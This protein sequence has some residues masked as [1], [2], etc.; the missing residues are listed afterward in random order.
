[1]AWTTVATVAV[2]DLWT[3]ARNNAWI[4]N[5]FAAD[6]PSGFTGK[7]EIMV[8]SGVNT[9]GRLNSLSFYYA[10]LMVSPADFFGVTWTTSVRGAT[11]SYSLT[12]SAPN[13]TETTMTFNTEVYDAGNF[14]P[15]SGNTITIPSGMGGT[16][17]VMCCCTFALNVN[18]YKVRQVGVLCSIAGTFYSGGASDQGGL[19]SVPLVFCHVLDLQAGET[20]NGRMY[21]VSGGALNVTEGRLS[22]LRIQ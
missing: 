6:P 21:Q 18:T 4:K 15:G 2:G 19:S 5:N 1:M 20:I 16:Y 7:G 22:V 17:L 8:G 14:Y 3:A 13:D 11:I 12:D 9:I 10:P